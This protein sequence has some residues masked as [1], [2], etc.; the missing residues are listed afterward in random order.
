MNLITRQAWRD[1]VGKARLHIPDSG[2]L[3]KK[4]EHLLPGFDTDEHVWM[5]SSVC[6]NCRLRQKSSVVAE[7]VER[8]N[9]TKEK[10][11]L[12]RDCNGKMCDIC[13]AVNGE[14]VPANQFAPPQ[15]TAEQT[16]R[17]DI[18]ASL[19]TALLVLQL[20][21]VVPEEILYIIATFLLFCML[22]FL[23]PQVGS[24]WF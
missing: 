18:V 16:F 9:T 23:F 15:P 2:T 19:S 11:Q 7:A 8:L 21:T 13:R 4:V 1:T 14:S 12:A 20:G 5:P 24:V 22:F 17:Y 3:Q 10:Q 6:K